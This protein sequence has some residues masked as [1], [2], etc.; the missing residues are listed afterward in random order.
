VR[1]LKDHSDAV[2]GV[3]FRPDGKLL[4]SAGADRAV[5][6]WDVAS[7]KRLYTL[8]ECT[9][10]VYAVAWAPD[11]RH[12]AAAGVDKSIRVWEVDE[13]GGRVVHSVFAHEGPVTRLA[14]AA[15]GKTLYSL[16]EDRGA[17][18]W[19]AA[20]MVE[21]TVY[22]RQPETPLALAV[23]PDGKQ[24]AV[25]RYDGVLALLD[26]ATGKVQLEP[27]PPKPKPPLLSA[28]QPPA[29][30]R[31]Q[32]VKLTISGSYLSSGTE[33]VTSIP[34][35]KAAVTARADAGDS[36]RVDLNIPSQAAA[37][38]YQ[39]TARTTAG[40]SKPLAFTIDPFEAVPEAAGAHASPRTGQPVRLP[41]TVVG[42]VGRAGEVDYFRFETKAGQE[43]GVQALT[44]P[45]GSKLDPVLLLADA[46]GRTLA[47]STNG[48]L[49]YTCPADGTYAVG[50]RDREFRGE[51]GMTYRLHVGGLPVVT[52]VF[53]LG[54]QRGT[55]AE[56][57]VDGVNLDPARTARVTAPADAA[58]GSKI[59]VPVT[60]PG[61]PALGTP[62]VVVG[63]FPEVSAD[64]KAPALPVPG[65]A[66]G[67]VARPGAADTF[68]FAAKKGQRLLLEVNARRLGSPLDSTLEI[69]DVS[70]RPLPLA[71]LR[72]LAKTYVTFRDHDSALPGI[73]LETWSELAIDD[74]LLVGDE[75]VRIR[76][77]P[78]NPDDD[79]HFFAEHEQRLAYLGTT[80]T[81]HPM[82]QPMYK[83]AVHPP[84][85]KFPPNGLPVVTL[86]HRNDDGGP[87]FGKD[88][89]LTFDPPADGEYLVRVGDARGQG[90]PDFAYRLT[91]RP[92]RPDYRV[93][94]SPDAPVV[95]KGGA[96]PV[97]VTAERVDGF[98]GPTEVRLENLPPGFNAPPTTIPA[99]ENSTSFAL[100]AEPTAAVPA[101]AAPLKLTAK[102]VI[103]GKEVAREASGRVPKVQEPG[104]LVTTT[105]QAE[106]TVNPGGSARV[107]VRVERRN[108]HKGRVPVEVRGLPHGV[109]VLDIGLNGI[110]ITEAES[111]RTMTVYAEP[112]VKP[113]EHPIVVLA[114]SERKGT[115]HAAKSVLLKI[116]A[117]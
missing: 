66:N 47:E 55:S 54:L 3:A 79:C 16:S 73:R 74:Y 51:S 42:A 11:G 110:L 85:T 10:W 94:F 26:A 108:G 93:R 78:K 29:V 100:Y 12:V 89:R 64:P 81:H 115:E 5:K 107:T 25:G 65:T 50:V 20:R 27:L 88:S 58:L 101:S 70:G 106:V 117:K 39:L 14:Y 90:G 102:A 69:L 13:L 38:V 113:T 112:W 49:G 31:G 111:S 53:P 77:L 67:R 41:V 15:D 46:E 28:V 1:T 40:Q 116:A 2:Y 87:G 60:T 7:G 83:V 45:I 19:D 109:R 82:G 76:D 24:I 48:L 105:E 59:P 37:G 57:R 96:V 92:P 114:K 62:S 68:R 18:A 86:Y 98:D 6:V 43:I 84:G 52:G 17:K 21:R 44:G 22:P 9:D 61:G 104:D 95:W 30:A 103:G 56:V 23:R 8:G 99:G 32:I 75:L 80:P 72:C 97:A 36:L 34:G 4:A 71:T 91:V 63:E 35:A 33:V